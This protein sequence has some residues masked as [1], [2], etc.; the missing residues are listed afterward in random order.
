MVSMGENWGSRSHFRTKCLDHLRFVLLQL[1]SGVLDD[2]I[3]R[4]A[5][6]I[7][8]FNMLDMSIETEDQGSSLS[9]LAVRETTVMMRERVKCEPPRVS[10]R[11]KKKGL[12]V[13]EPESVQQP[14][15]K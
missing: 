2:E 10:L 6:L 1:S 15:I 12:G 13:P 9:S 3:P 14:K 5:E 11:G 4:S 7:E 8:Q